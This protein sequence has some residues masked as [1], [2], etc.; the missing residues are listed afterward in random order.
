MSNLAYYKQ[1]H[2]EGKF[3]GHSTEKWS[4]QIAKM[5]KEFNIKTILDFG[6][7]KGM[8]Y[9]ELKLHE[10]WGVE[11]PTLYDPAVPGLDKIPNIMLP[12]DMVICC[13]VLEHLE[14][15]ELRQ[16]VF[17]AT[18]RARKFCF[19]GIATFPAKKTLP[20]GRNAHLTLWSRDVWM[21]FIMDVRFQGDALVR[22]EFDGGEDGR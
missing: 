11:M 9:T 13:D 22:V 7:G 12:F 18:I 16:A 3:P 19:F 2:A 5:I 10:K 14:G 21:R 17:N 15:E 20:D 6:S 4:D 1:M 8:Q